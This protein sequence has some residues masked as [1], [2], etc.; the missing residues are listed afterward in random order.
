MLPLVILKNFK[1]KFI[2]VLATNAKI[3]DVKMFDLEPFIVTSVLEPFAT[4]F[5]S[6]L[7][8]ELVNQNLLYFNNKEKKRNHEGIK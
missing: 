8:L 3:I 5:V 6:K 2:F 1:F 7:V 4:T